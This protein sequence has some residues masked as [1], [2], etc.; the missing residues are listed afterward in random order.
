MSRSVPEWIGETDD[1]AI[2]TRVKDRVFL[3]Q[4][5]C[6]AGCARKLAVAGERVEYDHRL[7]L[8][9]GG[10]N[11]ESNIQA[12]CPNC[13]KPKTRADVA[14]KS[15]NASVRA[16]RINAKDK[17]RKKSIIPGSKASGWIKHVDGSASRRK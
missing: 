11:R 2:P 12:L 4:D 8:I 1:T 10:E 3:A 14:I 17:T 16:K 9:N 6:C 13:H 15:K 5:G 7:A